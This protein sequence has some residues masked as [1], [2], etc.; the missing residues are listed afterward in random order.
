MPRLSR[1]I[2]AGV[3]RHRND[4]VVSN[5]GRW[6]FAAVTFPKENPLKA[7]AAAVEI[8]WLTRREDEE[9]SDGHPNK[10]RLESVSEFFQYTEQ[11]G[12]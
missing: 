5:I 12:A 6:P 10:K 2:P 1:P 7:M 4:I 11:Q 8:P 9:N 3:R